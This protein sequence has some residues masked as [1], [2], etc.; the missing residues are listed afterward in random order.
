MI[1]SIPVTAQAPVRKADDSVKLGFVTNFEI[2]EEDM[3]Q[4]DK[5]RKKVGWLYFSE[6]EIQHADEPKEP[7]GVSDKRSPSKRLRSALFVL[8]GQLKPDMD[9]E[10][11]YENQ[12]EKFI[13][14]V[15]SKL[16]NE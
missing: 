5:M 11:W 13:E 7:A 3:M 6:N 9:F 2:S 8:H 1:K 10:P 12:M 14:I 4:L 15:K 16:E